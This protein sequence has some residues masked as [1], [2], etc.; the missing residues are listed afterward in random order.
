MGKTSIEWCDHSINPFKAK[1][2]ETG[3][4][5]HFCVRI[6][7]GCKNC[8]SSKMQKPFLTQLEFIASNRPKVDLFLDDNG[9]LGEVLRRQKPTKYFWCDMTDMLLE[10]YPDEWI[11]QCFA[12]MG[13]TH[14]HTH[15][16]LT[17]RPER[18]LALMN[19][20]E[21]RGEVDMW[22]SVTAQDN[23]DPN[24]RRSDDLRATA[25]DVEETWPLPNVWLGVSVENQA[26]ADE[27]IPLLFKTPAAIRFVSYEPA[28]GPVDF[29]RFIGGPDEDGVCHKCGCRWQEEDSTEKHECPPGFGPSLD[30]LIIGGESGP[31]ARPFNLEWARS[32]IRQCKATGTACFVKQLGANPEQGLS[33]APLRMMSLGLR[34]KKGGDWSEPD[35]PN[36]L[37]VRQFPEVRS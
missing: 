8:Y 7:P 33:N 18:L 32:T 29:R 23:C 10:D 17:K 31:G 4:V 27:R 26:T 35:F 12:V 22:I 37:K 25:P 5:G 6:S 20:K 15:L 3:K 16:V 2:K 28:L 13:L 9:A 19:S 1:N 14:W 24:E 34:D 11:A 21:F 36:D 30:Q